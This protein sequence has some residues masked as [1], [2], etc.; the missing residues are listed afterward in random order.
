MRLFALA[1]HPGDCH[2]DT[3]TALWV[4]PELVAEV[5]FLTWT[6]DNLLR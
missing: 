4:R 6:E 1:A 5:K 2:A 3:A